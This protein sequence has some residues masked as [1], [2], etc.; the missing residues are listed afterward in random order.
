MDNAPAMNHRTVLA[1]GAALG[2]TGVALG[3]FGAHALQPLLSVGQNREYWETASR[4]QLVHAAVLV[5]FAAWLRGSPLPPAASA[6]WAARLWIVGTVLFSGSLYL[7]CWFGPHYLW[8]ATPL[9][10][11]CLLA[12]WTLAGAA[13]LRA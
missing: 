13:A 10:G 9:G 1:W 6:A 12:G 8:L 3:A 4:Y 2:A 5:G 11:L 7:L